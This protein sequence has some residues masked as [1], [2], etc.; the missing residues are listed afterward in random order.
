MLRAVREDEDAARALGKNTLLFKLQSLAIAALLGATGGF[1]LAINLATLHPIDF[2]PV[3]TFFA[4]SVLV[5]AGLANYKGVF[6]G[7]ILFWFVIEGTRFI[8]LPDLPFTETRIAALRLAI[9]GLL[10]IGLMAFRPQ[11]LFGKREEMSLASEATES[12]TAAAP[13]RSRN[14]AVLEIEEVFKHFGDPGGQRGELRGRAQVDHRPDRAERGGQNYPVQRRHRLLPGRPRLGLLRRAAGVRSAAVRARLP[15]DGA[16]LPDHQGARRDAGDRQHDA[17]PPNQPGE[18]FRNMI[19]QAGCRQGARGEVRRGDGA[20]RA[21]QPDQARRRLRRHPLGW[22][23]Q[24]A[25]ARPGADDGAEAAPARR[26][27][28][29]INP[30]LGAR[31]LDHMQRLR[32]EGGV[33]FLFIEHDMEVVMNHSDRVVV[34]AEGRVIAEGEPDEAQ[35]QARDRRLSRGTVIDTGTERS[36]R[37]E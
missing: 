30:T 12:G 10:L 18:Q 24:A 17:R 13:A 2:E 35:R 6:V 32:R 5:L 33:T 11:G 1:F 4:F 37:D 34:M 28:G 7:A 19:F 26:A 23:A 21:L 31:L 14:G 36:L 27:D 20:A 3:I 29:G 22:P 16:D 9:T 8:E 15:G 25:R